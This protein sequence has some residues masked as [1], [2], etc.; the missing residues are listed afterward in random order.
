MLVFASGC[1]SPIGVKRVGEQPVYRQLTANVLS[2]G[3]PSP[4]AKQFLQRL[5]LAE[6]YQKDPKGVLAELHAGL[7]GP[8]E[9]DRLFALSELS[10]T[11]AE[12]THDRPYFL[13]AA[14]Y[15]YAYLFPEFG[16]E[17]PVPYD[18]RLRLALD[19]YNRGI[20]NGLA[21][22]NGDEVDLSARRVALPFGALDLAADPSGYLYGDGLYRLKGFVAVDDL[23]I[24]GFRNRYQKPGI[25]APLSARFERASDQAATHRLPPLA[26]VPVTAFVRF[27]HPRQAIS[28]GGLKGAIELYDV[29]T[30]AAVQVDGNSVPLESAPSAAL[31]YRLEKSPVWDFEIA[32]FRKA[33]F[34]MFGGEQEDGLFFLAP[35]RPGRIPVVFVH[36]TA[37]SPARWAEMA[38]ELLSDSHI[39]SRYQFWIFIYNSGNPVALSAMH[40]REG[41]QAARKEIDP[42]D[43]DPA[44]QDMVVMGHSQ[45]GLLTKMT[46]VHSGS[47]FW[48]ANT[49]VPFEQA[50]LSTESRDLLRRSIFVEPL[51]FVKRVIFIAT[52]HRGSFLTESILGTL[53]RRLISLP[54][55]ITTLGAELVTLNAGGMAKTF[56]MPTA[57]DN[58]DWSHPF[59]RTL[60]SLPI[61]EGVHAHSII[62]VKGSGPPEEG[63]DGVVKYTSAHID[64]VE[65]ELVVRSGHST[66]AEPATIEEVRRILYEHAGIR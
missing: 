64:G 61:A 52:P 27:A 19:L 42:A 30:T 16:G 15:A 6:R 29:D 41:L 13:A 51:P 53:A 65:S 10:F 55:T 22:P 3:R 12:G 8:D 39:A 47:R 2:T 21:T 18:P 50:N 25:G 32:G 43:A 28:A 36:G 20:A 49:Q 66:Q 54:G 38:N 46:V 45:G 4:Y 23:E 7:G 14:L 59:L 35:Y 40:L 48:D 60:A 44:L 26:K 31:A 63:N 37:S 57:I 24:R 1:T 17:P 34:H 9:R 5:S 62:P 33:N 11:Y 56:R 58:M